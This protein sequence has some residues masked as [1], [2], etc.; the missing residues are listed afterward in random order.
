MD[1]ILNWVAISIVGFYAFLLGLLMLYGLHRYWIVYL[2]WKYRKKSPYQDASYQKATPSF[3]LHDSPVVT[4]QLP[5]YNEFYV[6]GRLIDAVCSLDYPKEK[7]EIQVLDDSDDATVD[8]VKGKISFWREK[9]FHIHHLMR[10][11]RKGYKAGALAWGLER[12][13]GDFIAIFDA[14]F[15]PPKDFLHATLPYFKNKQ[16]GMVQTRWGHINADYSLLTRVQALFLDGH[17]LLEHTA[18]YRSGAFFNFNGTAGIWRKETIVSAGGWSDRTLT[19]DLDLSYRAQL[20]GWKFVFVPY[21]VCPAE[22]PVDIHAFRSQQKRWTQGAIQV[23]KY[24]LRDLWKASLPLH[25]KIEATAHLTS[26]VGYLLTVLVAVLLLP[27][28]LVRE[29]VGWMHVEFVELVTFFA[30]AI[31]I[32]FFYAVSLREIYPNWKWKLKDIP[33]LLSFGIG[34]CVSNA[35]AV[36]EGLVGTHFEFVR[37]P[38][39]GICN[40]FDSWVKNKYSQSNYRSWLPYTFFATYSLLSFVVAFNSKNWFSLPFIFLFVFGF[41]YVAGLSYVHSHKNQ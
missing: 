22:L 18:R 14:D 24:L 10:P 5:L 31:S 2:Y 37:T 25:T 13:K 34:M 15:I 7:L 36:W 26:N 27:T 1:T 39:Y 29:R 23:A 33:A 17:F 41:S 11:T 19:E 32:A 8:V 20:T 40:K 6:A 30:T 12:A 3:D 9:G 16:V 21:F 4:V 28:L 38:K 35:K